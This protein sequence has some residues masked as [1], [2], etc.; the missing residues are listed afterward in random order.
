[1]TDITFGDENVF[2]DLGF[3]PDDSCP[4]DNFGRN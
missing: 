3:S 2:V 1:M 4:M